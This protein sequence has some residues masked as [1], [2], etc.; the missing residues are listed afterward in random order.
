MRR[1]NRCINL[2]LGPLHT[3]TYRL[4]KNLPPPPTRENLKNNLQ[5]PVVFKTSRL[6]TL[7][8]ILGRHQL[9][10]VDVESRKLPKVVMDNAA[11]LQVNTS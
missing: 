8:G 4:L 11:T 6:Q 5:H 9:F 1:K 10:G 2:I 7:H 3:G